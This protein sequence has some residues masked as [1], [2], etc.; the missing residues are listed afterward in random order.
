MI[1]PEQTDE[2]RYANLDELE[3]AFLPNLH[4]E[5]RQKE[6]G[7]SRELFGEELA[8]ESI[9]KLANSLKVFS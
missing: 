8:T 9:V 5:R 2:K 3:K 4:E 6:S 7:E 1:M